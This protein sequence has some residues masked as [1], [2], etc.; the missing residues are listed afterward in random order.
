M[1]PLDFGDDPARRSRSWAFDVGGTAQQTATRYG[2]T[3]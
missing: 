3:A 2:Y 1:F